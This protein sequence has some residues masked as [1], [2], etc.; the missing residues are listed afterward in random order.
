MATLKQI[1]DN[2]AR[3]SQD[4]NF[5]SRSALVVT[6]EIN[7]SIRYY[8]NYRFWFNESLSTIT[9]TSGAQVVP[10]IPSDVISELQVNGLM[11]IDAQ[12]KIDL[13]KLS[14]VDFFV[15]DDDQTGRPE[16]YTYRNNEFLL[17]PTPNQAYSLIF[18]YLK[19]Y[20]DLVND[21]DTNDFTNN[22]EDLVMLHTLKNIYSEEKQD[23]ENGALYS[24]LERVELASLRTRS[25][26]RNK[27]GYL[28]SYSIL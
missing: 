14:P 25:D 22:A 26:N 5:T 7:R 10:S 4:P 6:D 19:L 24:E 21:N 8:Q 13:K 2:V 27:S 20:P 28:N 11:L 12:V 1:R 9:L 16:Y 18:R 3:K 17:L 15:M 23:A